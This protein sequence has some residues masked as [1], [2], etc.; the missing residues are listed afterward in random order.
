[1]RTILSTALLSLVALSG[2]GK[3]AAALAEGAAAVAESNVEDEQKLANKLS[4]YVQCT[5]ASS[6]GVRDAMKYLMDY[7]NPDGTPKKEGS[8]PQ[9]WE[10]ASHHLD[11][12][13]TMVDQGAG[14]KPSLPELE[15]AAKEYNEALVAFAEPNNELVGYFKQEDYKDDAWAK[16][17]D[18]V[19][20][21][22]AAYERWAQAD[23]AI[24]KIL[25]EK[26]D[27]S[28]EQ[29]LALIE[30]KH[31]KDAHWHTLATIG[32]AKKFLRCLD[33]ETPTAEGC[34]AAF[35]SLESSHEAFD[36]YQKGNKEACDAITLFSWYTTSEAE[37]YTEAKKL[38]RALRD[39]KV[40]PDAINGIVEKYNELIGNSNRLSFPG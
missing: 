2:C 12:C 3:I 6:N 24:S 40:E 8:A 20:K 11:P 26:E 9:A 23:A 27:E 10:I 33:V 21:I 16:A 19:P 37:Y 25:D 32:Q 34:D 4:F 15:A 7:V 28:N 29:M 35:N 17:K 1:M 13:K 39:G 22:V 31:G 30:K 18:N 5:N 36:A 38:M 14:Q